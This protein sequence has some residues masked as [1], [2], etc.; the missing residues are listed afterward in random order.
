MIT[1][2]LNLLD[3]EGLDHQ[4]DIEVRPWNER[5]QCIVLY[6]DG[7]NDDRAIALTPS[8]A[9]DLAANLTILAEKAERR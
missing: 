8:E 4:L 6:K 7:T 2:Q 1:M 3:L 5:Q 9:R